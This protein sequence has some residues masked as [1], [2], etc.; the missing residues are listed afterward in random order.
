DRTQGTGTLPLE[1]VVRR[2]TRETAEFYGLADRGL[3]APGM[4]ADVNIIDYDG[5]GVEQ[6]EIVHDLPSGARRLLQRAHGYRYTICAGEV[7]VEDD[8]FTGAL[9]GRLLRGPR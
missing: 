4:R 5:L 9:P 2:Q 8:R 7:T 3:L 6:P 1:F